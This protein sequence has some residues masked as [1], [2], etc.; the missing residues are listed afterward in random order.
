MARIHANHWRKIP[1]AS[2][3]AVVTK[4]PETITNLPL[5][6]VVKTNSN[7]ES[8]L[9][10]SEIDIVDICTPTASH[11]DLAMTAIHAGK[12][13]F[14]EK[15]LARSLADCDKIIAA[16]EQA[17]VVLM[18]GH[19][20]RFFPE[21]RAAKL[22][23]DNGAIGMPAAIRTSR[24][25]GHPKGGWNNWFADPQ[26]SGGVLLDMAIHDMDW[27]RWCFGPIERVFAKGLYGQD[28]Y[29]GVLD[30]GLVTFRLRSGAIAHI[31]GSWAHVGPF[32]TT[33]EICGDAGM[34]EHDSAKSGSFS[35][36]LRSTGL[37]PVSSGPMA[38]SD[39]PYYLELRELTD[40]IVEGRQ[41]SVTAHDARA[42]VHLALAA[43]ESIE[44]SLPVE[45]EDL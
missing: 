12:H 5:S 2:I 25:A 39:D 4:D 42:A 19:V 44:T 24:T 34:I 20:V 21:F 27:I 18:V 16:A 45:I 36:A 10:E 22:S 31:T 41:P 30:Y 32:R 38:A 13:V 43:V 15:P 9:G 26:Q 11:L 6:R 33:F 29:K 28:K 7:L 17:G 14:I 3:V 8:A 40:S 23:V 37:P 1:E 35:V